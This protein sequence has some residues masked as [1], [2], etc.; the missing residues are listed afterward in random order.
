ME[1]EQADH[2]WEGNWKLKDSCYLILRLQQSSML[3]ISYQLLIIIV[4]Y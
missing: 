3:L 2:F 1:L 4:Y